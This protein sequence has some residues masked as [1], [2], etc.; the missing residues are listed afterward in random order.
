LL[1]RRFRIPEPEKFSEAWYKDPHGD[2]LRE[3]PLA[4]CL[5]DAHGEW[6]ELEWFSP[7]LDR[8]N[9]ITGTFK[10]LREPEHK[11]AADQ[12]QKR[13]DD[14]NDDDGDDD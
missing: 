7:Y 2:P 14:D 8:N 5:V 6:G 4:R 9:K 3:L 11:P 1:V 13:K 10:P 12:G